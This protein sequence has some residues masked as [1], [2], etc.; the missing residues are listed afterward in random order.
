ML[1]RDEPHDLADLTLVVVAREPF[2]RLRPDTVLTRQLDR[3]GVE[4]V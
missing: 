4:V 2:E 3:L 1:A